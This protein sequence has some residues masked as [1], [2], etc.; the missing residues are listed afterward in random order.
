VA[1]IHRAENT[2]DPQ[3]LNQVIQALGALPVPVL[4]L[5]HPRLRDR[6]AA[7]GVA[8]AGGS[9]LAVG[10]QPYPALIRLIA[11]ARCILTDS[12]G[13]QKESYLLGVVCTTIRA[14]TEWIET[15][16][17]GWNQ[18]CPD[19]ERLAEVALRTP[20]GPRGA[21]FGDGQAAMHAVSALLGRLQ[22]G[23]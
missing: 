15:L 19:L 17:G 5:T 21:P 13:L 16:S 8:L 1:T 18:L 22:G 14:E 7:A 2:D 9:L 23:S 10:P 6:A 20:A 11:D 4:L 3:R 12:G